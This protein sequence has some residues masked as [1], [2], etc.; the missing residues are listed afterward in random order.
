[1]R[2]DSRD[3]RRHQHAGVDTRVI[4]RAHG[5]QPLKRVRG[6]G[7]EEAPVVLIHR[8]NTKVD[9]A[10]R[11][12]REIGQDVAITD[13]HGSLGDESDRCRVRRQRL[14]RAPRNLVVA[15]DRLVGIG[16]R[17]ERDEPFLPR[18]PLELPAQ[19]FSEVDLDQN[20]RG[21]IVPWTQVELRVKASGEAVMAAVRATPIGVQRPAKRHALHSIQ[22]GP[23]G[24]LLV[25]GIVGTRGVCQ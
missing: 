7:L 8:R 23:A 1:M 4:Q 24:D 21:K 5:P 20:D 2:R 11:P 13:R 14:E 3:D 18:G 6:P 9:G 16:G 12:P 19:D 22:R 17:A 25:P 15:F 10:L